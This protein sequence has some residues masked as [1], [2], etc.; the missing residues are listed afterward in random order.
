M[1]VRV[2]AA[3]ADDA[4]GVA[5]VHVDSWR[6]TY[7]G[8]MPDAVLD[9]LSVDNRAAGWRRWLSGDADRNPEGH[10]CI[11]AVDAA[12]SVLGWTTFGHGRDKGWEGFGEIAGIYAHP[13]AWSSG[14]GHALM[15]QA[16][17][18]LAQAGF[19]G[20][21]LWMLAGNARALRFYERH[22]WAADG[23]EKS[24]THSSGHLMRELRLVANNAPV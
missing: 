22:G 20:A 4:A 11:V 17:I 10:Q 3:T 8:L 12:D 23:G 21:Y 5:R 9:G 14:V 2:R 13:D 19:S 15:E 7:K 18:A 24:E 1:T 16:M 6:A